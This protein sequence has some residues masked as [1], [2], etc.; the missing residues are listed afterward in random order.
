[1]TND[2]SFLVELQPLLPLFANDRYAD[3]LMTNGARNRLVDVV[4]DF[5]SDRDAT[6]T[7][8]SESETKRQSLPTTPVRCS[9]YEQA[10]APSTPRM[11][12]HHY[13]ESERKPPRLC[14][15]SV[16]DAIGVRS[17]ALVKSTKKSTKRKRESAVQGGRPARKSSVPKRFRAH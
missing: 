4:C 6:S 2:D 12:S 10:R 14:L 5:D 16:I 1:M 11:I 7:T 3:I 8:V 13:V 9:D 15:D 17:Q